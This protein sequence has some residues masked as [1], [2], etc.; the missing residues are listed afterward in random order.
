VHECL[1]QVRARRHDNLRDVM[2]PEGSALRYNLTTR[3]A[4]LK[5]QDQRAAMQTPR[6]GC[7]SVTSGG[8]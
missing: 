1:H 7:R 5:P 2:Q 6:G 8:V 4:N 3:G